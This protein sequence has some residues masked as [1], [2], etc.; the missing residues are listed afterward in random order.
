MKKNSHSQIFLFKIEENHNAEI[1]FSDSPQI[2]PVL[3]FQKEGN[4]NSE[5][6]SSYSPQLIPVTIVIFA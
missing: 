3:L 5:I 6:C 1:C 2:S 4:H